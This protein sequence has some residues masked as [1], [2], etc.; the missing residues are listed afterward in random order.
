MVYIGTFFGLFALVGLY[1]RWKKN[2]FEKISG[3][4][5][6]FLRIG[7]LAIPLPWIAIQLGWI[8]TEVGRQP[9]I[10]QGYMKTSDAVSKLVPAEEVLISILLFILIFILLFIVWLFLNLRLIKEGPKFVKKEVPTE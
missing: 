7:V 4:N 1:L 3:L 10:V 8:S 2:L 9:W 6:W 5:K